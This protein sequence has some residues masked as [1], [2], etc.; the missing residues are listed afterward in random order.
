MV[1]GPLWCRSQ[2]TEYAVLRNGKAGKP[3]RTLLQSSKQEM[4]L[5]WIMVV[6]VAEIGN[7]I[8]FW[9]YENAVDFNMERR[10]SWG[11][12]ESLC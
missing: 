5:A 11:K 9:I 6:L 1:T 7:V 10:T 12:E 8:N 3:V 4:M 2:Y